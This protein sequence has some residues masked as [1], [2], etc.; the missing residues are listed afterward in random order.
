MTRW[1]VLV[2]AV[3]DMVLAGQVPVAPAGGHHGDS[4]TRGMLLGAGV[5]VATQ[6][7]LVTAAVI[8]HVRARRR[9]FPGG[10]SRAGAPPA[11][12]RPAERLMSDRPRTTAR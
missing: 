8:W 1:I 11:P 5:L 12:Q 10:E 4:M 3:V 7:L 6:V 2:T 9:T